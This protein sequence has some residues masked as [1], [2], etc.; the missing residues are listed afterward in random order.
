MF[1]LMRL[2]LICLLTFAGGWFHIAN[3]ASPKN[4][5]VL[6]YYLYLEGRQS[7]SPSLYDRDAYQA[8]LRKNPKERS[9][10]RFDIQWRAGA[11][12]ALRLRVEV[13]GAQGKELTK[14]ILETPVKP[15]AFSKWTVLTLSTQ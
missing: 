2:W 3:A 7:I 9:G 14:S 5:K 15:G 12:S 13:R 4:I 8:R 11:A 10:L 1:L 6:P